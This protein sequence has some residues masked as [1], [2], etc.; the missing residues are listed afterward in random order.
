MTSCFELRGNYASASDTLAARFLAGSAKLLIV[1]G[2][3]VGGEGQ[4]RTV[5]TTIFSRNL[6]NGLTGPA[7]SPLEFPNNS[8]SLDV[9]TGPDRSPVLKRTTRELREPYDSCRRNL[10]CPGAVSVKSRCSAAV[11]HVPRPARQA[12]AGA[13]IGS[14][15]AREVVVVVA[16]SEGR[17]EAP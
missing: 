8:A 17:L 4:N 15:R 5:D 3:A 9:V 12:A 13:A 1:Q 2:V 14:P 6:S 11:F 10:H 16:P 7:T